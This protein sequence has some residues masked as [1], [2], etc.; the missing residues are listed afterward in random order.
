MVTV[1]ECSRYVS[2]K[3]KYIHDGILSTCWMIVKKS[4]ETFYCSP[5]LEHSGPIRIPLMVRWHTVALHIH[6]GL[7]CYCSTSQRPGKRERVGE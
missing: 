3:P 6:S 5:Q 2:L 4:C 7:M 1:G